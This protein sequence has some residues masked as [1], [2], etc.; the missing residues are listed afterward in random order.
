MALD[1]SVKILTAGTSRLSGGVLELSRSSGKHLRRTNRPLPDTWVTC[2][3][4]PAIKAMAAGCTVGEEFSHLCSEHRDKRIGRAVSFVEAFVDFTPEQD[5][6]WDRLTATV[7]QSSAAI[8]ESCSQLTDGDGP[9]GLP[10]RL[11]RLETMMTVGLEVIHTIRPAFDTFYATLDERQK[12]A[13]DQLMSHRRG[14]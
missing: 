1:G 3:P 10:Q 11:A 12:Q 6:A 13:I 14:Q 9:T 8:G 4:S 2:T 7:R 5:Q